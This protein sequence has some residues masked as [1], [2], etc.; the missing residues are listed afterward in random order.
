MQTTPNTESFT[1]KVDLATGRVRSP[2]YKQGIARGMKSDA[3]KRRLAE[4]R[5]TYV[6]SRVVNDTIQITEYSRPLEPDVIACPSCKSTH[7]T[8]WDERTHTYADPATHEIYEMPVGYLKC[9]DCGN[10]Y[11]HED[12]AT[13]GLVDITDD[14]NH[15][16]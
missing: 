7:W 8:C 3:A 14:F 10:A 16:D 13:S 15:Q 11:L 4:M 6:S 12:A 9:D 1:L 2:E 5:Y